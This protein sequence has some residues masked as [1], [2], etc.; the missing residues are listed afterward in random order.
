MLL[1]LWHCSAVARAIWAVTMLFWVMLALQTPIKCLPLFQRNECVGLAL[2]ALLKMDLCSAN[3]LN[4]SLSSF[5]PFPPDFPH[6]LMLCVCDFNMEL[7]CVLINLALDGKNSR[8]GRRRLSLVLSHLFV[9][10]LSFVCAGYPAVD[11]VCSGGSFLLRL[12]CLLPHLCPIMVFL[13][14]PV[15]IDAGKH[16]CCCYCSYLDMRHSNKPQALGVV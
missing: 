3:I 12:A 5:F 7:F 4:T 15:F 11:C 13:T 1:W 14:A 9:P 6:F 10:S 8:A 16:H 2:C